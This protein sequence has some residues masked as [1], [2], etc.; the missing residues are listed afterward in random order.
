MTSF[1]VRQVL[2]L[3]SGCLV[4]TVFGAIYTLGT[5]TPYI[6][7]YLKYHGN[8]DIQVVD[9]SIL[10]PIALTFQ[11]IGLI[12]SMYVSPHLGFDCKISFL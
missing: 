3:V 10:Y 1:K 5:V 4:H 8:P 12:L 7:S 11:N 9:I 2:A 6:G